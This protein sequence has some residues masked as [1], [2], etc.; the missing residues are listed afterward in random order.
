MKK[1]SFKKALSWFNI[2]FTVS[3]VVVLIVMDTN[4]GGQ[5]IL[6]QQLQPGWLMVALCSLLL[7]WLTDACLLHY[8]IGVLY[9]PR[10]PYRVSLRNAMLGHFYSALTPFSSGGQPLQVFYMSGDG[11]PVGVSSS[12]L[13]VKFIAYQTTIVTGCLVL[14][15]A[16]IGSIV[17]RFDQR[18]LVITLLGF[19][20]NFMMVFILIMIMVSEKTVVRVVHGILNLCCKMRI[21]RHKEKAVTHVDKVLADYRQSIGF[22]KKHPKNLAVMI[23]LTVLELIF[24]FSIVYYVYRGFGLYGARQIDFIVDHLLHY[25]TVAFAP[26][27][28]SSLA[29]EA[30]F[31]AFFGQNIPRELQFSMMLVWRCITYYSCL[32][33][34]G[35]IVMYHS[36][37]KLSRRRRAKVDGLMMPV[38]EEVRVEPH[39]IGEEPEAAQSDCDPPVEPEK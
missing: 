30:G 19:L 3:I 36:M 26:T 17:A 5:E 9:A 33:V 31:F 11:I 2:I 14:F 28:G 15:L 10:I 6:W 12:A 24:Y 18:L 1:E 7:Y 23:G 22:M 35:G 16:Q 38:E 13:L 39:P 21:I 37:R 34:G 29:A 20:F 4:N 25:M 8:M 27:P 32:L